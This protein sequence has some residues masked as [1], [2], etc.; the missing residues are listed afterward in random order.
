MATWSNEIHGW[1][2]HF[3]GEALAVLALSYAW[4]C[5]DPMAAHYSIFL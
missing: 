2:A 4:S 3:I 5:P 1:C